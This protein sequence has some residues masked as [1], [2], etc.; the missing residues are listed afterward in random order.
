MN[1]P[2]EMG[3]KPSFGTNFDPFGP[4]LNPQNF[5]MY[6]TTTKYHTLLQAIIVCSLKEN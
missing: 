6:F 3:K 2:S 4:N 5:F 1:Q